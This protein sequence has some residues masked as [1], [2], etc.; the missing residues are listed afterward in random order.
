[1]LYTRIDTRSELYVSG[2]T[3]VND[4]TA[5][6]LEEIFEVF[7]IMIIMNICK[8]RSDGYLI[9]IVCRYTSDCYNTRYGSLPCGHVF[10][11]FAYLAFFNASALIMLWETIP[12]NV[13]SLSSLY[14][15]KNRWIV[16]F[17][18]LTFLIINSTWQ[19]GYCNEHFRS[20]RKTAHL[21]V[22]YRWSP[23][24]KHC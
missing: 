19:C 5:H 12:L 7:I 16:D 6:I 23:L 14:T 2:E 21:C 10:D 18:D 15:R 24:C 13:Y 17:R 3:G 4:K 8:W 11:Q 1:M 22:P 20:G 9:G